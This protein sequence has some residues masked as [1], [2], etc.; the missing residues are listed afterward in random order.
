MYQIVDDHNF[1]H[2]KQKICDTYQVKS[3]ID[4]IG[5]HHKIHDFNLTE[6]GKTELSYKN[7]INS[8]TYKITIKMAHL[9]FHLDIE[10]NNRYYHNHLHNEGV[11]IYGD[12]KEP[13]NTNIIKK[14]IQLVGITIGDLLKHYYHNNKELPPVV[15][16]SE[17]KDESGYANKIN[18][19]INKLIRKA[20]TI[21][22]CSS[23]IKD[24]LGVYVFK[25]KTIY[26]WDNLKIK[27]FINKNNNSFD[28]FCKKTL[29][30]SAGTLSY[31]TGQYK[32]GSRYAID[33][34]YEKLFDDL[35][36][37]R[38]ITKLF[39]YYLYNEDPELGDADDIYYFDPPM[40][41]PDIL[42][43]IYEKT[44][45]TTYLDLYNKIMKKLNNHQQKDLDEKYKPQIFKSMSQV[46]DEYP[47]YALRNLSLKQW[48][49][50][51]FFHDIHN[52]K[53][54]YYDY[55][56]SVK[57]QKQ[58]YKSQISEKV[59]PIVNRF[60]SGSG[61]WGHWRQ[62]HGKGQN[63]QKKVDLDDY[64]VDQYDSF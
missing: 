14:N 6:N 53:S 31:L 10:K 34:S 33:S 24:I 7:Q 56:R 2:L 18:E 3:Y 54:H 64:I 42:K 4:C 52:V 15:D 51:G 26:L 12:N 17:L 46:P 59:I 19:N 32:D 36:N 35:T 29:Y 13:V 45:D 57:D 39:K 11:Y 9:S 5:H 49:C 38:I 22:T 63:K 16:V 50:M 60:Y 20:Q 30:L 58:K 43:S 25:D 44:N 62:R 37:K 55:M 27:G 28:E 23:N 21:D 40:S 61:H 1:S 47:I 48:T 8:D 41:V